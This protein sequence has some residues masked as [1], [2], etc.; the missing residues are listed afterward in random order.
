MIISS[1][2]ELI[3]TYIKENNTSI[4]SIALQIGLTKKSLIK[5]M[6]GDFTAIRIDT[7]SKLCTLL[8]VQTDV[9]L[10]YLPSDIPPQHKPYIKQDYLTASTQNKRMATAFVLQQPNPM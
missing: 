9:L 7:L 8:N 6:Y 2:G 1:I 4:Q 3:Q 10:T 5:L